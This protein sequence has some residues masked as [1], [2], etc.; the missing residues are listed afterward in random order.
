MIDLDEPQVIMT[1]H[2]SQLV[3][4]QELQAKVS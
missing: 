3:T 4:V 1:V 2:K